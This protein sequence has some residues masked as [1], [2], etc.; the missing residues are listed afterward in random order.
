[1]RHQEWETTKLKSL[2][3]EIQQSY[4]VLSLKTLQQANTDNPEK[5][6]SYK[7]FERRLGGMKNIKKD[8]NSY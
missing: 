4:G 2:V 6:P 8:V 3:K 5:Y 1:M 7:T